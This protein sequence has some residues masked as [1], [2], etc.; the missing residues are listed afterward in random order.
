MVAGSLSHP[1]TRETT[2]GGGVGRAQSWELCKGWLVEA[3]SP[4]A[5]V[6]CWSWR[7]PGEISCE[8]PPWAGRRKDKQLASF[9]YFKLSSLPLAVPTRKPVGKKSSPQI[10]RLEQ[11]KCRVDLEAETNDPRECAVKAGT[12]SFMHFS[13]VAN[14]VLQSPVS[15][16]HPGHT[17]RLAFLKDWSHLCMMTLSSCCIKIELF[18][19][20]LIQIVLGNSDLDLVYISLGPT[21]SLPEEGRRK[22]KGTLVD[23][24]LCNRYIWE[25][26]S[27]IIEFSGITLIFR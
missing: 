26:Y 11:V 3:G 23:H 4:K 9:S 24:L 22:G 14:S 2:E 21:S 13:E 20:F 12:K 27:P 8:M 10:R 17:T 18:R 7:H 5:R 1:H 19:T 25:L 6:A 16:V 15:L